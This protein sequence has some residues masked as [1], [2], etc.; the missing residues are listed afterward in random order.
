MAARAR[1]AEHRTYAYLLEAEN[2]CC[3]TSGSRADVRA[4][5]MDMPCVDDF[6]RSGSTA[7]ASVGA[8]LCAGDSRATVAARD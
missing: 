3:E 8:Q 7:T 5:S 6:H 4:R 1:Q 2:M